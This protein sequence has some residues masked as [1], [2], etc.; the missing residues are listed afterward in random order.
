MARERE[1]KFDL[2]DEGAARRL[3]ARLGPPLEVRL[4]ENRFFDTAAGDLRRARWALRLRAE[5]RLPAAAP[6][7]DAQVPPARPPD[8]VVLSMKGSRLEA[9]PLHDRREEQRAW[10]A[11]GWAGASVALEQLPA[12]WRELLP[13]LSA[14]LSEA[15]RFTNVRRAYRLGPRWLAEVDRTLFAGERRA[16]ELEVEIGP[17]DDPAAAQEVVATLLATAAVPLQV[18]EESKLQRAWAA[19]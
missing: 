10:P 18:Q 7:G 2:G 6:P 19:S 17:D 16:W 4:Q 3:E 12:G 8:R 11:T 9:G 15:V 14:P 1:L 13:P 5:W